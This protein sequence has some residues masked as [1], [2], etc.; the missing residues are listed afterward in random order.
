MRFLKF[1]GIYLTP[2]RWVVELLEYGSPARWVVGR[3]A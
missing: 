3:I 1:L 2:L